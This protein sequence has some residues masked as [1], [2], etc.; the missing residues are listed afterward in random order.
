MWHSV[1]KTDDLWWLS[2]GSQ[3]D[4][5]RVHWYW[6][7]DGPPTSLR[8]RPTAA[9]IVLRLAAKRN[10]KHS[11]TPHL[12]NFTI[13]RPQVHYFLWDCLR[14]RAR[15]CLL[16][17][18][19]TRNSSVGLDEVD[20]RYRLNYATVVLV[21]AVRQAV[22]CGTTC[23]QAACLRNTPQLTSLGAIYSTLTNTALACFNNIRSVLGRQVNEI[24]VLHL[25][26]SYCLPRLMYGCEIWPLNAVNV[27]EI[28]ILWNNGFRHVFNCCVLSHFSFIVTPCHYL[29]NCMKDSCCF[30][31]DYCSVIILS[32]AL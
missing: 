15:V 26:K 20:E 13:S 23:L 9:D 12:N 30:I 19:R 31:D 24:M 11:R 7:R 22:V 4:A 21:Q 8:S 32:C 2:P 3:T 5:W 17:I 6:S 27:R 25:I 14:P 1:L 29:I 16:I 28:D 10:S 18:L